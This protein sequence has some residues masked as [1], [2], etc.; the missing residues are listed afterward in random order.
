[1]H[2]EYF[3]KD[4]NKK[5]S[6]ELKKEIENIIIE[7]DY[8]KACENLNEQQ[9]QKEVQNSAKNNY[10]NEFVIFLKNQ[11]VCTFNFDI[12]TNEFQYS[13][14]QL[15]NE[16]FK[17]FSS[18]GISGQ[19]HKI[20]EKNQQEDE[21]TSQTIFQ[22]YENEKNIEEDFLHLESQVSHFEENKEPIQPDLVEKINN[23]LNLTQQNQIINP[24]VI[25][26]TIQSNF[27]SN[28]QKKQRINLVYKGKDFDSILMDADKRINQQ[29]AILNLQEQ[30]QN[31]LDDEYEDD[32]EEE[33]PL[34]KFELIKLQDTTQ[35]TTSK[36]YQ[37]AIEDVQDIILFY[38]RL[39]K[40]RMAIKFDFELDNFQK[41]AILRLEEN[42][43][44]FVCAHT[45]AGKTVVAEYAIALA[46][47]NKRKAIYTSPIKA[48]SNQKYRDFKLKFGQDVGIVT[49]DVSL[50][51]TASCLIVT[52]E[53]LR[54][55]LYKGHDIIRDISWVI[56]DE[57]HYV[58]NQD[59]GVVWEETIIMLPESIGLVMLSATA[60]NYMDFADWVGRTK[61][62]NIFVQKTTFR[63][64]PLEH[65]IYV[66]EKFHLVKSRNEA[67]DEKS[68]YNIKKELEQIDNQRKN[69][70]FNKGQMLAQK[71]EKDIYKNTNLSQKS[72][73]MSKKYTEMYIKK[74]S[75]VNV[76]GG[77]KTEAQQMKKLLKYCEKTKLL[78]CVVFVF[79]KN[80]IKELSESLKNISFCSLEERRK[81]EEF[82]NKFSRNIK[83]QDLKVQQI[84]TIKTLMMCGIGVHHGDVIPFVKEIVEILFSEGLIKVLFATETFAMGINMP[85]KTAIFHSISKH[86]GQGRRILNSSEYTQM[87]GRAGRRGLDEQGNCII[88]IAEGRQL[89]SK[90]DL[91]LMMDSKGEVLQSKFKISY[92][93]I[94]KLLTSQEINVTDMMKKSY[95]ENSKHANLSQNVNKIKDL[96]QDL[97]QLDK[98][99]CEFKLPTEKEIPLFEFVRSGQ[100]LLKN[101]PLFWQKDV[102]YFQKN[103]LIPSFCLLLDNK[104]NKYLSLIVDI[105]NNRNN[106][107]FLKC[108][109]NRHINEKNVPS[110]DSE[111]DKNKGYREFPTYIV[112]FDR[113]D[114]TCEIFSVS[115]DFALKIYFDNPNIK[116]GDPR[117]RIYIEKCAY[118]LYKKEQEQQA[119][120]H[121]QDMKNKN[122]QQFN[123]QLQQQFKKPQQS[124][125]KNQFQEMQFQGVNQEYLL[126]RNQNLEIY[127]NSTCS[128]CFLKEKHVQ[129]YLNK[130]KI[131]SQLEELFKNIDDEEITQ[132]QSFRGKLK[133]L[134]KL[135]YTDNENL[136]LLKARVAKEIELIYVC[137]LLVQGIFDQLTE[138]EL[139]SLLSCFI[140]QSKPKMGAERY[141]LLTDYDNGFGY[142]EF[143]IEKYEQSITILKDIINTE[144]ENGVVIAASEDD[145]LQEVFN[146]ELSKV[147][148]EWMKGK[149]FFTIC[150]LTEVQEGSIIRCLVRLEN[151]MKNLKNAAILLGNNQLC[152]KIEQA[153][154]IMKRDI[155]FSQSLYLIEN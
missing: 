11:L 52:T 152:M 63:P 145:Y 67:L 134:Q 108:L 70:K 150:Q 99:T 75:K 5:D 19:I 21:N 72:K 78:P 6:D 61:K 69:V 135:N 111:E 140:C 39:P 22:K 96:K 132:L 41:R 129:Q 53:V 103:I 14:Q 33:E 81:I 47:K 10:L 136:P 110:F 45:S 106:K 2:N 151:L 155:V 66:N 133:V 84:Q 29:K 77:Q 100:D 31:Q 115:I 94:L 40:Q 9:I 55:M 139:A 36:N 30:Q 13:N 24:E 38:D 114:Y 121:I 90:L 128:Q 147:V 93:I 32:E 50:N 86:D 124:N 141:D 76:G 4:F 89:P 71:K 122:N 112:N 126:L 87:S 49:G 20:D 153:Q 97:I 74:T 3:F 95:L 123:K 44:V 98:I 119:L 109:I 65:S 59:R 102:Q 28:I 48:L 18:E 130:N 68:Y 62:K 12:L 42:E 127:E 88:F 35:R 80:K 25:F 34:K 27:E 73:A 85:T 64:V 83:S 92:E 149:D 116:E 118:I 120:V 60:P 91:K 105:D 104:L 37:F 146:P 142:D 125:N 117:N 17:K 16:N 138:P 8:Q 144:I 82:F 57:V 131:N 58:N 7:H 43:S 51:P 154:D 143:F 46:K 26:K 1:M 79:S 113:Q 15:I 148:Y 137:E 107:K 23:Q 101:A 56:F 54:N